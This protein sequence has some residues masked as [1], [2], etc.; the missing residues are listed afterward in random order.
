M[1]NSKLINKDYIVSIDRDETLVRVK[2]DR[3]IIPLSFKFDNIA[4]AVTFSIAVVN[5]IGFVDLDVMSNDIK[6]RS[7]ALKSPENESEEV[8]VT[9]VKRTRKK[10]TTNK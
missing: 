10:K 9:K 6:S 7:N 2:I 5:S 1:G 4:S 8:V 3:V